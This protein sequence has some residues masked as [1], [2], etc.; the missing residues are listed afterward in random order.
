MPVQI[1]EVIDRSEQ[2]I[3]KPFICRGDDEKIYFVK[4]RGA[5]RRSLLCEWI[6]GNLGL[7]LGL[8]IAPFT[9]VNVPSALISLRSRDDVNELGSGPAFGSRRRQVVELSFTHIDKVPIS[10]R[11][12]VLAF[13]W[14]IRNGDRTLSDAGGN[15]NLFWDVK[16]D[17]LVVLDHNQAFDIHFSAQNFAALHV[18]KRECPSLFEDWVAQ[19]HYAT[20]YHDAMANWDGICN[21]IPDEWW[22]LDD[23]RTLPTDF[24]PNTLRQQLLNCRGDAFWNMKS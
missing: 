7:S 12:D 17:Q 1:I 20:R 6:A 10:S 24:D 13:D 22:Y 8:P 18:F 2:G 21:T 15:P 11:R 14:W 5:G 16:S 3:T 4:G 19:E 23:E 9:V